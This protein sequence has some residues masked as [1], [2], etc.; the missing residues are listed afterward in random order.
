LKGSTDSD[1][2]IVTQHP[3]NEIRTNFWQMV[4]DNNSTL[5]LGLY[6]D[7]RLDGCEPYWLKQDSILKCDSFTV[8]LKDELFDMDFVYRDFLLQSIDEDYEFNC[9]IICASYWPDGCVSIKSAFE[10]I[11][12]VRQFR[13]NV[14]NTSTTS[15]G[16]LIIHDIHG[17]YRAATFC[18]L[19]TF[20]DLI[21][22][23]GF[24]N[25]Y[26]LAKMYHLKRPGIWNSSVS[27][28]HFCLQIIRL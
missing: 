4:W 23:E 14:Q 1:E 15:A 18:C 10:L 24:V 28:A 2:F 26:E 11:N 8:L 6:S 25:V 19:Y 5:V 7:D 3:I 9:R 20:Q 27:S 16:P 17:G 12:R 22:L 13:E 21:Q